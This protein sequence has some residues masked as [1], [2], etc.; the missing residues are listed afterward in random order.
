MPDRFILFDLG[1]VVID[2]QP[3]RLYRKI[4]GNDADAEVFCR[5]VCNMDWHVEHDR[6]RTFAEGARLLKAQF[7]EYAAEIDAWHGR[8]FEMFDGYVSG[9]P[10]LMARLEEAGHPL[11][12]LSN[13]S[14]EVWPETRE[15]FAMIKLLRETVISGEEKLIKPDPALYEIA[16]KRMGEPAR[17]KVFFIDDSQKNVDAARQFGFQAHRF[18]SAEGLEAAL[19][20]EGL[21]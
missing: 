1:N 4:F 8:W 20:H 21:L 17:E 6:G 5:D 14:A 16:H 19:V 3:V 18:Q 10:A 11:F 7:P 13:M 2:W 12:G 9:V 15:R